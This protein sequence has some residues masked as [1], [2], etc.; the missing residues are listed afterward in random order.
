MFKSDWPLTIHLMARNKER[1]RHETA[2][3]AS[4]IALDETGPG[5]L[6]AISTRNRRISTRSRR[7]RNRRRHDTDPDQCDDDHQNQENV[8]DQLL[9]GVGLDGQP[10]GERT[11]T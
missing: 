3:N 11:T 7:L 8:P 6:Y 2:L 4:L 9:T 10:P 5:H 1:G